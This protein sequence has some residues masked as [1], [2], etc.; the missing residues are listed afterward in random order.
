MS[1]FSFCFCFF[2]V[3][4]LIKREEGI[5]YLCRKDGETVSGEERERN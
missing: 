3:F 1:K 2:V 4:P 5:T